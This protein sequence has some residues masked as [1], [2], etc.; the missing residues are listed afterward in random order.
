MML[1]LV[2][3]AS[4]KICDGLRSLS[5]WCDIIRYL[6][7]DTPYETSQNIANSTV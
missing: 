7:L 3:M 4:S 6:F 2:L 1:H 5:W